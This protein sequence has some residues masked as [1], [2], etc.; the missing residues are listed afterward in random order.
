[1]KFQENKMYIKEIVIDNF[2]CFKGKFNLKLKNGTNVIVGNN[3][4]GKSTILEAIHLALSGLINGKYLKTELTQHLFNNEVIK[5]YLDC[6]NN[7]DS[8][9]VPLP[10]QVLIEIFIESDELPLFE[11]NSHSKSNNKECGI[12]FK[13]SVK[14]SLNEEYAKMIESG[15]VKS[16]PIEYYDFSWTSFARESKTPRTIPIKSALIDSSSN[17]YLNGSDVYISRIVRDYL[18]P[19]DIIGVSKAHRK[20]KDLFA[21]ETAV[22]TIN[23]KI[24]TAMNISDKT[25]KLSVDLSTK[26]A[27]ENSLATYLDNVPFHHIG[28]GEQCIVKTKLALSHKKATEANIILLEE[29]ENHLSHAKLNQLIKDIK[30]NTDKQLIISTHNSYVANKLGLGDLIL[31]NNQKTASLDDLN[32][33]TRNFFE[34]L[35]GYD[36]LR[37]ILCKKAI[38]VEGDSDELIIQKAYMKNNGGRLPIEDGIDVISVGTSFLRFL[39]IAEKIKQPVVVVTDND[40]DIAAL[41]HKY[42]DYMGANAK[43][44]IKICYDD[45]EDTGDLIDGGLFN[46]N[47][48]E[49]KLLKSNSREAF[50]KIFETE[51]PEEKSLHKYMRNNKT[52]CALKLFETS[53]EITFPQYIIDAIG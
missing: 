22:K 48:L 23:E 5:E 27:W 36:T 26:N 6:L 34:K 30:E 25:I 13:I 33:E 8:T 49:P 32:V 1:M 37:L 44:F 38:L 47:T 2:K 14:E 3:E 39:E 11:G 41:K 53:E 51:Y 4:A 42:A 35:S 16:L 9:S 10:P 18:E 40:G 45:T 24:Q 29:P 31:L 19:E 43:D 28:K 17:R 15:G 52:K 50:N 12:S 21:E 46:Y 20:L 7:A